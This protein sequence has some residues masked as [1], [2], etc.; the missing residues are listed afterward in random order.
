MSAVNRLPKGHPTLNRAP[1]VHAP[2]WS[3]FCEVYIE[4]VKTRPAPFLVHL[5]GGRVVTL[6]LKLYQNQARREASMVIFG[7]T[8]LEQLC[9]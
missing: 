1:N 4:Q 6:D 3:L 2:N 8:F 7:T 9:K 5:N